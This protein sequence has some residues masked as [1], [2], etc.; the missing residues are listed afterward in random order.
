MTM[1]SH[2]DK[3]GSMRPGEEEALGALL[4]G[5]GPTPEPSSEVRDRVR[6]AVESEWRA[7]VVEQNPPRR[8]RSVWRRPAFAAAASAALV[9]LSL[10]L[11][12][13]SFLQPTP[14]TLVRL[15]R[16]V[17]SVEVGSNGAWQPV[18]AGLTLRKGQEL[19]TGREGRAQLTWRAGATLRLDVNTRI[20]LMADDRIV[21]S[22]GAVYLDAGRNPSP[23][24]APQI[25]SK[26]G[27]TR[28]VGTQYEVRML[29][30]EM[31][32]SV[33]EGRVEVKG[34]TETVQATAGEQL[35]IPATGA[36]KR[37]T[38][39]RADPQWAWVET[40]SPA[41]A[42]EQRPLADFLAWVARETGQDLKFASSA[43]EADAKRIVLRGSVAGLDPKSAMAA[44]M[45]T[46][47]LSYTQADGLL[48]IT[49]TPS[50]SPSR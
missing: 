43:V 25:E 26:F 17:G 35:G 41:F 7:V 20:A 21:V 38:L 22:R 11:L 40:V 48:T 31:L 44:V 3:N 24:G 10:W 5:M 15:E 2:E 19:V 12:N 34:S 8:S 30:D 27:S 23:N 29:P 14:T 9:A 28:H 49:E 47:S 50:A 46:T 37:R 33:R 4:R 45:A 18:R 39:D 16:S 6:R 32:V 13:P 1:S 36:I 42:I